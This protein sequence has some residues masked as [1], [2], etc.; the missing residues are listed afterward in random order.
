MSDPGAPHLSAEQLKAL[1]LLRTRGLSIKEMDGEQRARLRDLMVELHLR[2]GMS[3]TDIARV[4]G[5]KT[6]GYTS[7]LCRQLEVKA[8]P[9]EEARLKGIREKRRKYER[10]PFDG[11]E[12]D[13]AYMLGLRHGD[14]SVYRPWTGVVRISTSTTHP[15]MAD[16]FR[17]VFELHGHVYRH[18]RYKKDTG[19]YEWN[20]Q[21][22]LDSSFEFLLAPPSSI[23]ES[24]LKTPRTALSYLAGFFDAEGSIGIYPEQSRASL[25]VIFYNTNLELLRSVHRSI[26]AM[27][28]SPL[29]PYM[30]KKKGFRSTGYK[31]EMKKDYWRVMLCRFRECQDFLRILPV[32][33][34]EKVAKKKLALSLGFRQSWED[35]GEDVVRVRSWIRNTRNAFVDEAKSRWLT[36]HGSE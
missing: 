13:K 15:A 2:R 6:S 12:E 30:D 10:R 34:A 4:I 1:G 16:L 11:T 28:F 23:E 18:P 32:R 22:I 27:G 19:T 26:R 29:P 33:H 21:V 7:W 24:V 9:F 8:R 35:V 25:N 14:L 5:N 36:S 17:S 31:I 20:L 3:L